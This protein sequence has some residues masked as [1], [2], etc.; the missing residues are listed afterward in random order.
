[1]RP[2]L[3]ICDIGLPEMSGLEVARNLRAEEMFR[4]TELVALSGYGLVEDRKKS[5]AAGFTKHLVKPVSMDDI[6]QLLASDGVAQ[7]H[8]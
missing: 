5:A 6:E 3:V 2:D 7:G 4:T 1:M 8:A